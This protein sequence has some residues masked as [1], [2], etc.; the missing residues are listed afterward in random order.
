MS[1]P[2]LVQAG[3]VLLLVTTVRVSAQQRARATACMD[4]HLGLDDERLSSPA[5]S[6]ADDIHA[7]RGF[8]CLAC[9][10]MIRDHSPDA[11]TGF[12]AKPERRAIPRLCGRCHSDAAFMRDFN[13]SLRVDQLAEYV[14]SGHGRALMER[15]DADVATCVDCHPAHATR[16]PSDLESTVHPLKVAETCARCHADAG[17][18]ARHGLS[19][20]APADYRAGVHGRLV[21]DDG[22]VSA[23]TCNDC[24][25]NHG[26]APPGIGS[27]PN[28]C[29]QCHVVMADFFASSGHVEIFERAALPGCVSCHDN[30]LIR[31][32]ADSVLTERSG[33]VCGRCHVQPDTLGGEFL[34]MRILIDSL[35]VQ[36]DRSGATLHE[37]E[38]KGMEVTQAL[39]ELEE[40]NNAV[41]KARNAIHSFHIDP[42]SA[43]VTQGL[44]L[45]VTAQARGQAALNDFA[46]RRIGLAAAAGMIL[47]LITGIIAR[48]RIMERGQE[49]TRAAGARPDNGEGEHT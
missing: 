19:A 5:R 13:P 7:I 42:V 25:G 14:T 28:V 9:H 40:V 15:N 45:T 8:D 27:V 34:R 48:I 29:G 49:Q 21:Q 2:A 37:A 38:N 10:G 12:L 3:V 31:E 23:P 18:M 47:I 39:F 1:G 6:F 46:I 20:E 16:P 43:E 36:F 26:A 22:D 11:R 33:S 44:Q 4:C 32:T 17:L 30:H 35:L 41:T 24:H